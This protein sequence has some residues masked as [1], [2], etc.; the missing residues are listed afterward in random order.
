[1]KNNELKK[2]KIKNLTCYYFDEIIKFEDFDRDNNFLD[3]KSY[4]N[5]LVYNIS[6]KTLIGAKL[7]CIRFDEIEGFIRVYDGVTYLALFGS[8]KLVYNRIR[9]IISQKSLPLE[10]TLTLCNVV[11]LI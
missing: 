6:Y 2:V 3:E 7:L 4:E 11:I 9:Y 5:I 1:M 10:K 8:E